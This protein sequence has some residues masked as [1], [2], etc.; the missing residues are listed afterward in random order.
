MSPNASAG[1]MPTLSPTM[2]FDEAARAVVTF[3]HER[4]PMGFWAVTRM[5]NGNQT[6]LHLDDRAYGLEQGGSYP[7]A[8]SFCINMLADKGP[9][10]APDVGRVPVYR[11][12]KAAQ[13]VPIGAYAGVPI[14]E[15]D[16]SL[17]GTLCGINMDPLDPTIVEEQGLLELLCQ[18]LGM[19]L[20]ADRARDQALRV[21][22]AA[23]AAAET[24][25]LTGLYSR[26]AWNEIIAA[27]EERQR[28]YADPTV[29]AI[30]DLDL[31]KRINDEQGHAAGDAYIQAA[32]Q[33]LRDAAPSESPVARLGGDEFALLLRDTTAQDAHGV[34]EGLYR[35]LAE[36]GV[37][38][39]IGWAPYTVITGFPG[40]MEVADE[41]MY[42]A[43]R[44]RRRSAVA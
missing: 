39:S 16:G 4:I 43:K 24:D 7:F 3:L 42:A 21:A 18:L 15:A 33:A 31:L 44:E 35:S 6:Y 34:V 28:K 20:V 1:T 14:N 23:K 25:P 22:V 10:V 37:A 38:G 12:S 19:V 8:D 9:R 17:F 29:I 11:D 2:S 40:A 27:E 26:H 41:R 13:D 30:V 5:E 36:A 32:G